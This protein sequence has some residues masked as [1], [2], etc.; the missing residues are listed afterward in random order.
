MGDEKE[1]VM[2]YIHPANAQILEFA[3]NHIKDG[4]DLETVCRNLLGWFDGEVQY[5][6]LDA[7]FFP[8][9]RS[10]LDL[11]TMKSGTCGDYS[12]LLVSALLAKGFDACYAYVHKD[13]YGDPQDHI[14][15]AVKEKGRYILVDATQ[16]YRKW[17]GFDC[18]HRDFELLSPSAFEIRIKAE[19]NHWCSVAEKHHRQLLSGLLYAPWIHAEHV[20]ETEERLDSVFYLLAFNRE[21]EPALYVYY[22][23]YT[24]HNGFLPVMAAI[25]ESKTVYHFSVHPHDGLWDSEQWSRGYL[26]DEIPKEYLQDELRLLKGYVS[27]RMG[28]I[29]EILCRAGCRGLAWPVNG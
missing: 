24:R 19:E 29:N 3:A 23:E 5:S 28:K 10:D 27:E 4:S 12:N 16:P 20:L 6:R 14:C 15:A 1:R 22:R 18:P 11:L 8:L 26:E 21:L 25:S 17:F 7:P 2:A 13:C 9:Q